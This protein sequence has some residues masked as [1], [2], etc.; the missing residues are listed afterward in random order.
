MSPAF[1]K[2]ILITRP[3]EQA[4]GFAEELAQLGYSVRIEP[5][6]RISPV[7]FTA[8]RPARDYAGFVV[9]S[10]HALEAAVEL[11]REGGVRL[12]NPPLYVVGERVADAARE[13]GFTHIQACTPEARQLFN[14]IALEPPEGPLL[15]L[16]GDETA[17]PLAE[18]LADIGIECEQVVAYEAVPAT[19]FS[20]EGRAALQNGEIGAVT[21]FSA[22]TARTFSVLYAQEIQAPPP[23]FKLLCFSDAVL[24]CVRSLTMKQVYVCAETSRDSMISLI[25]EQ[26]PR[27]VLEKRGASSMTQTQNSDTLGNAEEIIERFGGIRPMSTK[28]NIPVTTIQGWKKRGAIPASRRDDLLNAARS[29]DVKL[30]DLVGKTGAPANQNGDTPANSAEKPASEAM[31]VRSEPQKTSVSQP[32]Y[33]APQYTPRAAVTTDHE[34]IKAEMVME[35]QKALV[36][37]VVI[38][39]ALIVIIVGAGATLLWPEFEDTARTT[40]E[41][42]QSIAALEDDV[43]SVKG[44]L[45]EQKSMFGSFLPGDWQKQLDSLKE[46]AAAAQAGAAQALQKAEQ[47]SSDV[48]GAGSISQGIGALEGHI[49]QLAASPFAQS[50]LSKF[51]TLGA[52]PEGAGV[53]DKSVQELN[54]LVQSGTGTPVE[55]TLETAR[56]QS[57]A[58]GQTFEGV[59]AEDLKA[60]A[61]LLGF[62]QFRSSLGRDNESFAEDVSLLK[63]LLGQDNPALSEAIDRLAPKA[64]E[65]GVLTP[66]GLTS[67]LQAMTGDIVVASLKGENVSVAEKAQAHFGEILKVEKDGE[68]ITGTPVQQKLAKAD[69][70]MQSGQL[71][72]AIA[73]VS[74]L[75]GPAGQ[76]I[77]PWIEKARRTLQAQ[78]LSALLE[79][80]VSESLSGTGVATGGLPL[81]GQLIEDKASGVILYRPALKFAPAKATLPAH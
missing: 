23:D 30:E 19:V 62:S 11:V 22:R 48:V 75:Q 69:T 7:S 25:G 21:L 81:G 44:E 29:H 72:Q 8:A 56:T 45:E 55:Q 50:V 39:I 38:S 1:Q 74:T 66:S 64:A 2:S 60:A 26:C 59:P 42:S 9:T 57:G 5:L 4:R 51:S 52:S 34:K 31:S 37:S 49:S 33:A 18:R 16:S 79:S 68:M 76:M 73:E 54:A 12:L 70:L 35:R 46:Q 63:N 13:A 27:P 58:L 3:L 15:Y 14:H 65:Q 53:L 6:L 40:R 28:T 41:N 43:S 67:E 80:G 32:S 47:I 71:E 77:Q 10:L 36:Q 24:E 17:F 20:P 61:L 78:N